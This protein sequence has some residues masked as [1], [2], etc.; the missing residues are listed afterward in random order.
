MSIKFS[1]DDRVRITKIDTTK[2]PDLTEAEKEFLLSLSGIHGI[3]DTVEKLHD[4]TVLY[5]IRSDLY[6]A[7]NDYYLAED[8]LEK[9]E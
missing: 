4:G 1:V 5:G 8:E 9:V 3:V 6:P 2:D 7:L